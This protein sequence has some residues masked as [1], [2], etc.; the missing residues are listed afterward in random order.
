MRI[1]KSRSRRWWRDTLSG[2]GFIGLFCIGFICFNAIPMISS[3][4]YSFCDYDLLT[5][6]KF[7]GL[8]NYIKAMNDR[9]FWVSLKA[10]VKYMLFS[11]PPKLIFSLAIAM[12]LYKTNRATA[13]YRAAYYLP[14]IIGSSVAIAIVWRQVFSGSGMLNS[15]INAIFGTSLDKSWIGSLDTAIWT[16]IILSV[17]Q[18][19]SSMLNFLSGLKQIPASLYESASIDGASGVQNFFHITLPMLT[20]T[21]FF[22]LVMQTIMALTC[23]TQSLLITRGDPVGTT[24]FS[25]V[26]SYQTGMKFY[27][28]GYACAQSW[29]L[30]V[31]IVIFTVILFWSQDKWVYY[32]T[33]VRKGS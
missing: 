20:P 33:D 19:G 12:L 31:V 5:P 10:T 13:F 14:S 4:V 18:F 9:Q 27:K 6:P 17:W 24:L 25:T 29:I 26:Y 3:F 30:L 22:N 11:V 28:M 2:Y 8:N 15:L 7:N 21:I 1:L 16:L 23:F 32:E